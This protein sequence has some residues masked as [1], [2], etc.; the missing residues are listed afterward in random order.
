VKTQFSRFDF[1]PLSFICIF[2]LLNFIKNLSLIL[3][4]LFRCATLFARVPN[5][6]SLGIR[7]FIFSSPFNEFLKNSINVL[8]KD[9]LYN[10]TDRAFMFISK[11]G[12]PFKVTK[13]MHP[14][15]V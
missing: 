4:T 14:T 10:W 6:S 8:N 1:N 15:N 5:V 12:R 2:L 7:K 13:E 11:V 3:Q 9:M